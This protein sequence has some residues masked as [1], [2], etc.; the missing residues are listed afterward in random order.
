VQLIFRL[1]LEGHGAAGQMGVKN[2]VS[3]PNSRRIFTR[4]GGR[5]GIARWRNMSRRMR[6]K[7][8]S[9]AQSP[10]CSKRLQGK[11]ALIQYPFKD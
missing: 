9:S 3:T 4:D 7:F 6:A 5:W 11:T 10:G 1:A 8:G 2:I